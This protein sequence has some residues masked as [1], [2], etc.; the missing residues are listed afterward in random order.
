ME[1]VSKDAQGK[2]QFLKMRVVPNLKGPTV[3]KFAQAA[4]A[5]GSI[6]ETDAARSYRKALSEKY[7]HNWDIYDAD[8]EML[9]WLHTIV[10]NA[11]AHIQGTYHG[12][13]EKYLQRYLDEFSYRFNRRFH[14]PSLFERLLTAVS[15]SPPLGLVA[16]KG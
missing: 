16:L 11:K 4:I 8:K 15:D 9:A 14:Q 1:A 6:I 5:Q 10:S 7:K 12:I 3:G 13:D 2:P